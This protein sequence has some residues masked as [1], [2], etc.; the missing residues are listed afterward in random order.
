MPVQLIAIDLDDTLLTPELRIHPA[1]AEAVR[2]ALDAGIA[3]M[4]ASGRTVESM[5]PFAEELGM[6]G[7]GLQMIC[8]NGSEVRDVDTGAVV[9]R[10]TL[11]REA[12]LTAIEVLSGYGLPVQAYDERGIVV[13][14]R[15]AWTD[16]DC[17]I[18]GLVARVASGPE[19][20]A[21]EPRSKLL[22][23]GAPELIAGLAPV[24]RA[25]FAGMAE[26]VVSKPYFIEILPAG[27]DKGEALAWVA[28]TRGIAREDVMAIGDSG[29]DL[30]MVSWAGIGCAPSDA[31][32]DVI[33]AAR[34]A[35]TLPHH[36]GAVAELIDRF[37]LRRARA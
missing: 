15:N 35:S 14:E 9:R 24:L 32:P 19:E 5:M 8:A 21:A 17:Q 12:C 29:N 10:L 6:K 4:L 13:S 23:A 20:I 16:R 36:E 2:E 18:T 3:V 27:A 1:N 31:R 11:S 26:I 25:R 33:A 34:H 37:A 30:G 22:S 7:R 28:D